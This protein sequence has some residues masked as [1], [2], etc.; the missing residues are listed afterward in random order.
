MSIFRKICSKLKQRR[1]IAAYSAD[2]P[3]IEND[4]LRR[5]VRRLRAEIRELVDERG[6]LVCANDELHDALNAL[7]PLADIGQRRLDALA[8]AKITAKAKRAAK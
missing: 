6:D 1:L 4:A 2:A 8:R 3:Q 5:T 7:R